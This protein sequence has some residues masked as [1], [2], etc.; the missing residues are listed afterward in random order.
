ME[1]IAA[2]VSPPPQAPRLPRRI[3]RPLWAAPLFVLGVAVLGWVFVVRP[4]FNSPD[5]QPGRDLAAARQLLGRADGD[6]VEAE[7]LVRHALE[8][9]DYLPNRVGEATLLLGWAEGRR[10]EHA[11]PTEAA[12]YWADAWRDLNEAK[13]L[14]VPDDDQNRLT[15]QLGKVGFYAKQNPHDA[16]DL[17]AR[18]AADADDKT[19]A[20]R[21]LTLAYLGLP[22]PDLQK[23]LEANEQLRQVAVDDQLVEARLLG[24]ELYLQLR[25]V[26]DARNVL[27]RIN[28][29]DPPALVFKARLLLARSYQDQGDWSRALGLWQGALSDKVQSADKQGTILYHLGLCYLQLEQAGE[30]AKMWE[31]CLA[32]PGDGDEGPAC[33]VALADLHLRSNPAEVDKAL[34]L[35]ARAVAKTPT[36]AAWNNSLVNL[37]HALEMFERGDV[38]LRRLGLYEAALQLAISYEHL[39]GPVKANVL[40]GELLTEWARVGEKTLPPETSDRPVSPNPAQVVAD[41]YRQAGAAY[42]LAATQESDPAAQATYFWLSTQRYLSG[43]D[44]ARAAESFGQLQRVEPKSAHLGEGWYL[45]GEVHRRAQDL[46]SAEAAYLEAMKF[47]PP[48]VFRARYQV[49]LFWQQ[50]GEVDNAEAALEQNLRGL[51]VDRDDEAEE[52]TLFA[53]GN[54]FFSRG[55]YAKAVPRLED[56]LNRFPDNAEAIKARYTLALSYQQMSDQNHIKDVI[57]EYK[58]EETVAHY[59]KENQRM[60]LR[61]A[62]EFEKLMTLLERPES[63]NQILADDV[64]QIPLRAA[65]CRFYAG[66]YAEALVLFEKIADQYAKQ[67]RTEK[68]TF[69][70]LTALAGSIRCLGPLISPKT[71][72]RE[73]LHKRIAEMQSVLRDVDEKA[74]HDWEGWIQDVEVT[75]RKA[76]QKAP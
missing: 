31:Q 21:L 51:R 76:D 52:K 14:G 48:F 72:H 10:A 25:R 70:Y 68:Q 58:N 42:A 39:A 7:K 38:L 50:R 23:A 30:A 36:P 67:Q 59:A 15:Y 37:A 75:L 9:P 18:T 32:L 64:P 66:Q 3:S 28:P 47:G 49:A 29:S 55:N 62:E 2:S 53:I 57:E 63:A 5:R 45:L 44:R 34:G 4:F 8:H 60:L 40:R 43:Q 22:K 19:E 13:S 69:D 61:A 17:L 46:A 56:A 33:A 71:N 41:C 73:R 74:K 11:P 16:A 20:Y 54:L 12:H 24:G 35:F 26:D 27:K 6:P 1:S 65:D